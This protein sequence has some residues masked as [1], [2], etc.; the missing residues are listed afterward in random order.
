MPRRYR[1]TPIVPTKSPNLAAQATSEVV[2]GRGPTKGNTS[3]QNAARALNRQA[4]QSAL[5]RVRKA[6][7]KDK[8]VK[9]SKPLAHCALCRQDPR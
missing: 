3:E 2:E 9:H 4:A 6:A 1:A 8:K 7:Q 5:A